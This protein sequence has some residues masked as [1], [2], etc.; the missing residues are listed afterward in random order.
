MD[1]VKIAYLY[2]FDLGM[3]LKLDMP[4]ESYR[5]EILHDGDAGEAIFQGKSLGRASLAA[6]LYPF[7]IG[8]FEASFDFNGTLAEASDLAVFAEKVHIGRSSL[9]V[10]FSS[11]IERAAGKARAWVPGNFS[12]SGGQIS[13]RE[14]FNLF[15]LSWSEDLG[16]ESFL[17]KNR[18]TLCGMVTGEPFYA[19]LSEYALQREALKNIGYYDE[20][21]ILVNRYGAFLHSKEEDTHR[22]LIS[23]ALAQSFSVRRANAYL[24]WALG[25][26]RGVLESQPPY[27]HFWK[28]PIA[29]QRISREQRNF[30]K[31][32]VALIQSLHALHGQTPKI[33]SDWHLKSVHREILDSF[34][35]EEQA[36][37]AA[38]RLEA[39]DSIYSQLGEQ[40]S[41]MFFIFLDFVFLA[42]LSVD[43]IGWI[44]LLALT[45]FK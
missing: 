22:E 14:A 35:I 41:T 40:L 17:K 45:Y 13:P 25:A 10:F 18:K 31:A 34:D 42:W 27:Y 5:R 23:L 26:A 32:K 33:E 29:Y 43:L 11:Q 16:A 7:G 36:K 3:E 4:E 19:R 37:T 12:A 2:C 6:Y 8:M 1:S 15:T 21:I 39:I 9:A 28:M 38:V 30:S 24:E 20:E 44:S